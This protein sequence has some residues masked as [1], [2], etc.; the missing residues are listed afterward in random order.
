MKTFP[1]LKP[2]FS[3]LI[4]LSLIFPYPY[5]YSNG[6][7]RLEDFNSGR[8]DLQDLI[9]NQ[10]LQAS[11]DASQNKTSFK[12][13]FTL[14]SQQKARRHFSEAISFD[15]NLMLISHDDFLLDQWKYLEAY[16][17]LRTTYLM[18]NYVRNTNYVPGVSSETWL[19][20]L[21]QLIPSKHLKNYPMLKT[22][23]EKIIN[24]F[25]NHQH[26]PQ[27]VDLPGNLASQYLL[28]QSLSKRKEH[29]TERYHKESGF[30]KVH[31]AD[32]KFSELQL[33]QQSPILFTE[34]FEDMV[35][36]YF[37]KELHTLYKFSEKQT[38][39]LTYML[40]GYLKDGKIQK[41]YK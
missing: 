14:E 10:R 19:H 34:A 41:W 21:N 5:A 13:L 2:L 40:E 28:L 24:Y 12:S 27:A 9:E 33:K 7:S 17:V 23:K 31:M 39:Q 29:V 11:I 3:L 32:L 6:A 30:Y 8:I 22:L 35:E 26:L 25:E 16:K 20:R 36:P 18:I 1:P 4:S 15:K 38:F 37:E